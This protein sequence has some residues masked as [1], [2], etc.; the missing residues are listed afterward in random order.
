MWYIY[1]LWES[2]GALPKQYGPNKA[3]IKGNQWLVVSSPFFEAGYSSNHWRF[4]LRI[5]QALAS[6][7]CV[8]WHMP[9][10]GFRERLG[11]ALAFVTLSD[12]K[13]IRISQGILMDL[14]GIR[15]VLVLFNQPVDKDAPSIRKMHRHH[16]HH[17]HHHHRP[18]SIMNLMPFFGG[19]SPF[20][21]ELFQVVASKPWWKHR[22][23]PGHRGMCRV[24][25]P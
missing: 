25:D 14:G 17:H 13:I 4:D 16:H 11:G 20:F 7:I 6:R 22:H 2:K 9:P 8:G 19:G 23:Y 1:I 24:L 12:A 21:Q 10:F 5:H 3:F 18:A 15:C